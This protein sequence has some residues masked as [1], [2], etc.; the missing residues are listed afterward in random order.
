MNIAGYTSLELS[1]ICNG[2]HKGVVSKVQHILIDSRSQQE[3]SDSLFVALVGKRQDG[4]K[5]IEEAYRKGVRTFLISDLEAISNLLA[6]ANYILVSD[7]MKALHQI[8][9][10]HRSKFT[11]PVIGITGSNGK[12]IVKEWTFQILKE[13]FQVCRSPKSYNSQVGVP[14]S[15]W[16]LNENHELA[17]FEAGISQPNEMEVLEKMIQPNIGIFTNIGNAHAQNF[18]S[19]KEQITEKL[20]L[21]INCN[22]LIFCK[23]HEAIAEEI[24]RTTFS[25][26]IELISWSKNDE[27]TLRI[28][29][30]TS[31]SSNSIIKGI[32]KGKEREIALPF[33]DSAS[34]E[35][36]IHVW[37][38]CLT[39]SVDDQ[40]ILD[41]ISSLTSI[42]MRLELKKGVHNCTLINDSY[43]S[44]SISLKIAITYLKQQQQ[45]P[46]H[47]LIL[48][49]IL[50]HSESSEELYTHISDL[51]QRNK[52][53]RFIGIG[54]DIAAHQHLFH[55][56]VESYP[57]TASFLNTLDQIPFQN[58]AILI[59]GARRFEFEK[60]TERL[61]EKG[62]NSILEINL[63]HLID[64][65]NYFKSILKKE[66]KVMVM[67]K[68]LS[69]GNGTHEIANILEYYR[70]DYLAVAY[71]DEGIS[72]RKQGI[73]LPI[74]VLN[75]EPQSF[76]SLV[77]Y[78][79]EPEIYSLRNMR[80]FIENINRNNYFQDPNEAVNIHLKMDTGMRRLGFEADQLDDLIELLSKNPRIKVV[81]V[82]S[83]LSASDESEHDDFTQL[84]FDRFDEMTAKLEASLGYPFLKHILNSSGILRFPDQQHDMVRLGIGIYGI[85]STA[86]HKAILKPVNRLIAHISQ[87]KQLKKGET[88]GYGRRGIMPTDGKIATIPIGYGDGISRLLGNGK[89]HLEV[90]GKMAPTIGSICMDM[91][92]IN[93]TDIE[94]EEGDEV[95]I[96][97][98]N[99]TI[100]ELAKV[101]QTIPYEVLTDIG[102]RLKRI[103]Y[104]E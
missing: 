11:I 82:F 58:E 22:S 38:L 99:N 98:E 13:V 34:I 21:F 3:Y 60:I 71:T 78:H 53:D 7:T 37:L 84:Q 41:G 25:K 33:K 15:V 68:A 54:P 97:G 64:N 42:A 26:E 9:S 74:M 46:K 14:L 1:K 63:N 40:I 102:S 79:L 94:A 27:A 90:N 93:I 2:K 12:T 4:H 29:S 85:S 92:M 45:H 103:F 77:R 76:D 100:Y 70:A 24:N 59:K 62:H 55:I 32:Y 80:L 81:S 19:Q 52:I 88:V 61:Q 8:A 47:T 17:L 18:K 50:Q 16:Q 23:D 69:Y 57:D 101:R 65:Y 75:P 87:I 35:D 86:E 30:I 20:K 72:L 83:H 91:L 31:T 5:Y 89:W 96:F 51:L 95:I 43:N 104:L 36:A 10:F 73:V 48:S 66:T 39:L 6:E 56:P 28:T 49:D 44:D 67:V